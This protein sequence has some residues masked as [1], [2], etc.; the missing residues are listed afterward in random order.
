M[1]NAAY[2]I[3]SLHHT[4][5]IPRIIADDPMT[6][7]VPICR[8][9]RTRLARFHLGGAMKVRANPPLPSHVRTG[10][11]HLFAQIW[12][13]LLLDPMPPSVLSLPLS[14]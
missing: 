3:G 11:A 12:P 5:I 9:P 4:R 1:S 14:E 8:L 7:H 6:D 13:K 10:A 2:T